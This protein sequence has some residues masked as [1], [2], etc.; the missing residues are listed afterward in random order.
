MENLIPYI[1]KEFGEGDQAS[2]QVL[3]SL[4]YGGTYHVNGGMVSIKIFFYSSFG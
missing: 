3:D 4:N 1:G 2:Y